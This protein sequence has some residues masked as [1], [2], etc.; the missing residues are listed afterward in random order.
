MT[1]DERAGLREAIAHNPGGMSWPSKTVSELLD[2]LD[3][4][5]ARVT[6][7]EDRVIATGWDKTDAE[8]LR[9][10]NSDLR[11]MLADAPTSEAAIAK[12]R[13]WSSHSGPDREWQPGAMQIA[14]P[15]AMASKI[16]N[17][18]DGLA[19]ELAETRADRELFRSTLEQDAKR[20]LGRQP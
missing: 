1:P 20:R 16:L 13:E 14:M 15:A 5:D 7:L 12:L 10:E 8:D 19:A 18:I 9:R 17:E 3:R 2:D 4:L 6:E 11:R